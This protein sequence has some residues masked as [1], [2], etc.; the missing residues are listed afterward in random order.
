MRYVKWIFVIVLFGVLSS[1]IGKDKPT[2]GLNVG[3]IAPDFDIRLDSSSKHGI[4]LSDFRGKYVLLS[5]WASY[6]AESRLSNASLYHA[7]RQDTLNAI[8]MI[9]VSFDEHRSV[10]QETV[11]MDKINI[12]TCFVETEGKHS[13]LFKRYRL[14]K[15]LGNYLLDSNGVIIAKD[16][17]VA[18]LP[19]YLANRK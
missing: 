16:I 19:L 15:G 3:N 12:P 6:D 1:F 13:A 11:R 2:G 17:S 14:M 7:L 4:D 8:E 18:E 5:F 9:S 10:F